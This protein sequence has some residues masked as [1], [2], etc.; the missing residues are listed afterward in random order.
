M[1]KKYYI[2]GGGVSGLTL[3]LELLR[4][5]ASITII[6]SS[7]HVGGLASSVYYE[8]YVIDYGPHLFH[9]AH[10]EIIEYWKDLVEKLVSKDFYSGN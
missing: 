6:E 4:K 7:D 5:G 2:I 3:A 1:V 9:S 8:D 10:P